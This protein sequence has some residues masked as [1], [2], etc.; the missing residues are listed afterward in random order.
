MSCIVIT[1]NYKQDFPIEDVNGEVG[2]YKEKKERKG[3]LYN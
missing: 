2:S 3:K 1:R